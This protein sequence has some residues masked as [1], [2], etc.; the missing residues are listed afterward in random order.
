MYSEFIVKKESGT[1]AETLETY[2]LANLLSEILSRNDVKYQKI[3]ISDKGI[4]YEITTKPS[5]TEEMIKNLNYFPPF[6]YIK[7]DNN[8]PEGISDYFDYPKQKEL[9]DNKKKEYDELRN[10]VGNQKKI[11]EKEIKGKYKSESSLKFESEYNIYKLILDSNSY[12]VFLKCYN[13]FYNN[14]IYIQEILF[15]ILNYYNDKELKIINQIKKD[16]KKFTF[17]QKVTGVQLYNPK[18]GK[19]LNLPKADG[20]NDNSI[21]SFWINE[22]LKISGSLNSMVRQYVKIGNKSDIK[23][24]VPAFHIVEQAKRVEVINHFK[25]NVMAGTAIQLDILNLLI[26]AKQFIKNTPE[27]KDGKIKNI[28]S[29]LYSIYLKDLGSNKAVSNIFFLQIP[30]FIII[31]CQEDSYLWLEILEDQILKIRS[32]KELGDSVQGLLAYRNF[33]SNS[34]INSFFKFS[35]WYTIYL[36]KNLAQKNRYI[37]PFII[38]TLDKFYS[39]ISIRN[40]N[41]KEINMNNFQLKDIYENEGFKSIAYAIRKSTVSLQYTPKEGRKFDIRYGLAQELQNKSKSKSDLLVFIGNFIA[42]YNSETAKVKERTGTAFRSNVKDFELQQFYDLLDKFPSNTVGAMLASYGFALT[43][44]EA[45]KVLNTN[46]DEVI[47]ENIN[48]TEEESIK[49]GE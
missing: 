42:T 12:P 37:K 24:F 3:I 21:K 19:G 8:L 6:R 11:R 5:I 45:S 44:K 26:L 32:I 30:D 25:G 39:S 46:K 9:R 4:Y 17:E 23:I 43:K 16:N 13:N 10:L 41:I 27:Y 14:K 29:G 49:Y 7:K 40:L 31:K 48:D 35:F 1:Y 15:E 34:D 20:L 2:G 38:D 47:D 36:S 22:T 28:V 18:Q 33:L